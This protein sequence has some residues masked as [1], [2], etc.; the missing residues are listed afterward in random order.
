MPVSRGKLVSFGIWQGLVS[1]RYQ[2]TL[3]IASKSKTQSIKGVKKQRK[4]RKLRA[5]IMK[6]G[7]S[8]KVLIK[9]AV[10]VLIRERKRR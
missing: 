2:W 5:F 1:Y 9:V 3:V 10:K 7:K 6:T 8:T 4:I